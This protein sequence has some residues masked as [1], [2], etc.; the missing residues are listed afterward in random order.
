MGGYQLIDPVFGVPPSAEGIMILQRDVEMMQ[1][2][3]RTGK[4]T[5][6][7]AGGGT[8][9]TT[10]YSYEKEFCSY[11]VN[12]D[13]FEHSGYSN[14]PMNYNNECFYC[15]GGVELE[16]SEYF[17]FGM[18]SELHKQIPM[19]ETF[20]TNRDAVPVIKINS[21]HGGYGSISQTQ[22]IWSSKNTLE[23]GPQ[24][25]DIG[26][27]RLSWKFATPQKVSVIAKLCGDQ[28]VEWKS[29]DGSFTCC[30]LEAGELTLEQMVR[31]MELENMFLTWALRLLGFIIW[32]I[33]FSMITSP[34]TTLFDLATIP[35]LHI[36]PGTII[37][38][39][40]GF[41]GF[42][43]AFVLSLIVIAIA[44]LFY[45][46]VVGIS[47]LLS[48]ITL[49][50]IFVGARSNNINN[51]N[52]NKSQGGASISDCFALCKDLADKAFHTCI[53]ICIEKYE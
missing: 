6:K 40:T 47:L 30:R 44:W 50:A 37:S 11:P 4:E 27:Y 9:N 22:H 2:V 16:I 17:S 49:Y 31:N 24:P 35:F 45:R 13:Y 48:G 46:P 21:T 7:L 34:L 39:I 15:E 52:D 8:K 43:L 10:T 33:S 1:W 29:D 25:P 28:L 18:S 36:E 5:E 19:N 14:P 53:N 26:T 42:V 20:N 41:A 3:E 38:W 51:E 32:G 12:S 23:V